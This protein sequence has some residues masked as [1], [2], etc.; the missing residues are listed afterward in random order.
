MASRFGGRGNDEPQRPAAKVLRE[1]ARRDSA[2]DG[3]AR[4]P[5]RGG[6]G[7]GE[8]PP[9]RAP[10]RQEGLP[11]DVRRGLHAARRPQRP[12]SRRGS[13]RRGLSS[14]AGRAPVPFGAGFPLWIPNG[15]PATG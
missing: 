6:A 10:E 14:G 9:R 5:D 2:G 15:P 1:Y 3:G 8:G 11:P 7:E 13:G 12:R 4:S